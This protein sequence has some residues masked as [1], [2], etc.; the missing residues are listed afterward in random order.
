MVK[1][2]NKSSSTPRRKRY[3]RNARLQNAEKWAEQYNGKNIA[4]GYSNW[5]L[6]LLGYKLKQSYKDKVNQSLFAR[7]KQK[8]GRKREKDQEP[9]YDDFG[10]FYYIEGYTSN[11]FPYGVT[12]EEREGNEDIRRQLKSQCNML[13]NLDADDL[14]F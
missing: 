11:G 4:K 6:N 12:S 14:P 3:N 8:E 10:P 13:T 5:F 2:K 1:S 7:Q 9:F